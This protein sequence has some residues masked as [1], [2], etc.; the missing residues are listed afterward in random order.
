M[1]TAPTKKGKVA[2]TSA[3]TVDM[4]RNKIGRTTKEAV[5]TTQMIKPAYDN[6]SLDTILKKE[7]SLNRE[8]ISG[9][10]LV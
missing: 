10:A 2:N 1:K 6:R 3:P 9:H 5:P 4:L 7:G 8:I